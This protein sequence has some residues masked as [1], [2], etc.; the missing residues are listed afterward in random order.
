[1]GELIVVNVNYRISVQVQTKIMEN[2]ILVS[3]LYSRYFN[4]IKQNLSQECFYN[5]IFHVVAHDI[6]R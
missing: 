2:H 1:M 5:A 6:I 4:R 3:K